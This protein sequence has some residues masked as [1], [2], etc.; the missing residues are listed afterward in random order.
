V[1]LT[2]ALTE[3]ALDHRLTWLEVEQLTEIATSDAQ[4]AIA[5]VEF[6]AWWNGHQFAS[7]RVV[8][9]YDALGPRQ[10]RVA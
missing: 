8:V 3:L 7:R 10:R 9:A 1:S 5:D 6:D 2:A 4:R